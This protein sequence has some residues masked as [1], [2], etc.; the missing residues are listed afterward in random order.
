MSNTQSTCMDRIS[1]E[2]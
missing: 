1:D 2:P